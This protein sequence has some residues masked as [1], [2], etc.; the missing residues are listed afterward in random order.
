MGGCATAAVLTLGSAIDES[1]K[2]TAEGVARFPKLYFLGET[3]T[4]VTI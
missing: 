4:N 3:G 1:R 2:E